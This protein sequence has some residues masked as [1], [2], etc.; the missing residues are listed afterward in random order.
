MRG[1]PQSQPENNELMIAT[2]GR[3]EYSSGMRIKSEHYHVT[4]LNL[5]VTKDHF[6]DQK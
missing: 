3:E 1:D 6:S 5:N 2:A 4:L